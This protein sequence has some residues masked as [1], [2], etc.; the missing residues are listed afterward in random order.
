MLRRTKATFY[1]LASEGK[2]QTRGL[3]TLALTPDELLFVQF[4]PDRIVRVP[5]AQIAGATLARTFLG[6][7]QNR[8][9][10]VVTWGNE[11]A[12]WDVPDVAAWETALHR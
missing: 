10:L 7:S 4:V 2:G 11:V 6:K 1:G 12:A 8:D 5:R 9:L 3:G